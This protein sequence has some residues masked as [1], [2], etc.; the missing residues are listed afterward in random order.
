[1][2]LVAVYSDESSISGFDSTVMDFI[3]TWVKN[4]VESKLTDMPFSIH[5]N[6]ASGNSIIVSMPSALEAK[7]TIII[8]DV[9]GR[10]LLRKEIIAGSKNV[11]IPIGKLPD[12]SY[13]ARFISG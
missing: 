7:A 8:F 3:G 2:T 6:P 1:A 13:F 10:E 11:E 9:L 12:G 4:G 5:P